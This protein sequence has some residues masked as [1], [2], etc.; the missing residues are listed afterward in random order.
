MLSPDEARTRLRG[1]IVPVVT[2]FDESGR[3]ALPVF[4]EVLSFLEQDIAGII[5]GDLVGEFFSLTLDE[6]KTLLAETVRAVAGRIL[7]IALVAA[8]SVEDAIGLARFA[9]DAGA[10]LIKLGLPYPY[11]P[12]AS[13]MLE[14][15]SRLDDVAGMPFLI[16]S[17]DELP[18]PPAVIALLCERPNFVGLEELGSSLGRLDRIYRDFGSRLAIM[19][20]GE[21]ALLYLSLRGAP[22]LIASEA[23]F[24]PKLM[25]KFLSACQVRD[26][27]RALELFGRR[28]RY[29]D[30]FRDDLARGLPMFTPY[31]KAAMELLGLPVGKPRLPEVA[32]RADQ[33]TELRDVLRREFGLSLV[34]G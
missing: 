14:L 28:R 17:S 33:I 34:S 2:P 31:T 1:V 13:A 21:N 18:I 22:G 15:F 16:E 32:L 27:D 7:T 26:L 5:P 11:T 4:H 12:T 23:N 6:R 30:L 3:L 19:P 8:A 9:R 10:D 20:S 29:R 24:V 25:G